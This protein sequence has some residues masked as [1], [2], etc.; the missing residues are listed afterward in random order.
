M[1]R[2]WRAAGRLS[3]ACG[4]PSWR[5]DLRSAGFPARVWLVLAASTVA[6]AFATTPA[7]ARAQRVRVS[8]QFVGFGGYQDFEPYYSDTVGSYGNATWSLRY[9]F[10]ARRLALGGV[11]AP[12][13]LPISQQMQGVV[14]VGYRNGRLCTDP[15]VARRGATN[16]LTTGSNRGQN[17][18]LI[19][20]PWFNNHMTSAKFNANPGLYGDPCALRISPPD[21]PTGPNIAVASF[22]GLRSDAKLFNVPVSREPKGSRIIGY[23]AWRGM[24]IW[25]FDNNPISNDAYASVGGFYVIFALIPPLVT[26]VGLPL[27]PDDG[28]LT[29]TVDSI[30]N[31]GSRS[32]ARATTLPL[33]IAYTRIRVRGGRS[34][35]AHLVITG[36]GRDLLATPGAHKIR[37]TTTYRPD[38]GRQVVN[39]Y[40]Y[41]IGQ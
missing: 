11:S 2:G 16:E 8:L 12:A 39:S 13:V 3:R 26:S 34:A 28:S 24:M 5:V 25:E 35:T 29:V 27:A 22:R 19:E 9:R 33:R 21:P 17:S 32:D 1:L 20:P 23:G 18:W 10:T 31:N 37:A 15:Q 38:H 41:T 7:Q 36:A 6:L 40:S 30:Y 4:R 14:R